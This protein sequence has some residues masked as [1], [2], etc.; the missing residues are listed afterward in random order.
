MSF[1]AGPPNPPQPPTAGR[2]PGQMPPWLP[3]AAGIG[4]VAVVAIVVAMVA[5]G[6]SKSGSTTSGAAV[7]TSVTTTLG[8]TTTAETT[9]TTTAGPAA[10]GS[11]SVLVYGLGDNNLEAD[12][13]DD[14]NEMSTVPAA[15]LTFF[16][17]ADR[18]PD[19]TDAPLGA[20]PDWE[21][22][23]L[24]LIGP[25][26]FTEVEDL[27]ELD[28]GDPAVLAD[29]VARGIQDYPA[30]HYALIFWDHGSIQGIGSDQSHGDG[31]SL[32]E[33]AAGVREGLTRAGIDR[34][35][36]I[37]FDA[38]L[39][40]AYEV[41]AAV[42]PVADYMI[43]S[44]E[45]EPNDG[46]D[47]T[48]FDHLAAQPD[49]VTAVSLGTEIVNRYVGTSGPND[50]TVTMSLVDLSLADDLVAALDGFR[51]TV[52]A[53]M[54]SF[55]SAIGRGRQA[56]PSF[57]A[58]PLPEE[59][60]YMVDIGAFLQ[61]LTTGEAPLSDAAS[62]ALAV[63]DEMVIAS[64]AGQAATQ[65]TGL[66]IHFPP[67]Q[68]YYYE[69][70]YLA[71]AAP[72][73]PDFLDAYYA[74][75]QDIPADKRPSFAAIQNEASHYFDEFGLNVEAAF[76]DA[77]V[78]NIVAAVLYTGVVGDDGTTTFIGEDQGLYEGNQA[79]GSN[80]LTQLILDDG[81]DR[82]VAYQDISFSEDF[83]TFVLDVPLAYYPPGSTTE[84]QNV[85]LH[86]TYDVTT[87]EFTEGFY[88]QDEFGTIGEF[89]TDPAGLIRPK[90]L[91]WRAD[92]TYEWVWTTDIGLWADLPNLTYSFEKLEPGTAIYAEL[93]VW[94]YGGNSDFAAVS[95]TVPAGES[96]WASCSNA[97]FGYQ[98]D[99][100]AEWF[101][102]TADTPDL[103]CSYV[104]IASME[105][106]SADDAF[107]QAAL[108]VEVLDDEGLA[109]AVD[110]F[111]TNA[112][113]QESVTVAGLPATAYQSAM[114]DWG[115]RAFVVPLEPGSTVVIAR[116][117]EVDESLIQF[118]D[119]V[120]ESFVI[121]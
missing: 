18:T 37:G 110:F 6:G 60:F 98:F 35:D 52:S 116:W 108:T 68:D 8:T 32:P 114:G 97:M 65:A 61:N 112:V 7:S 59:D 58:S 99:Y 48:A 78:D 90:M 22:A 47:Y 75:G 85:T 109:L 102:W 91:E 9:T 80:D 94:D 21:T 28:L 93:T 41:A 115:F 76:D 113:T 43:A 16:A 15:N 64:S 17:L 46:W 88:Y 69:N 42:G 2:S 14:L 117:G 3:L 44:E 81:E 89:Q 12:L 38:C 54:A 111:Q 84:Y 71:T 20:I 103:E 31:L 1:P 19:Y 66:A 27:G 56:A 34:L 106:L 101:V 39:M 96:A 49:T 72:V 104:D 87:E 53:D 26:S 82:A 79:V 95:A 119:R 63:F 5:G 30:D 25:G 92:G 40:A 120:A 118:A 4:I 55:G 51:G 62:A 33:I 73:W 74:A 70:W 121:G 11:W 45:V 83:N 24:L 50:P 105:G 13:L 86:L 57:G 100:P 77:A 107:N 36:I 10:G 29:F 67:Y 23:K